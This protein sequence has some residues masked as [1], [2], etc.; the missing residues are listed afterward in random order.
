[1]SKKQEEEFRRLTEQALRL[2]LGGRQNGAE[3][4]IISQH[5]PVVVPG[6]GHNGGIRGSRRANA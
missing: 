3:I 4:Q 5:H 1:M 2:A 6:K